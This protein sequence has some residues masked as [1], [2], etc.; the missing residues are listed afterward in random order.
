MWSMGCD[1]YRRVACHSS[2]T[3]IWSFGGGEIPGEFGRWPLCGLAEERISIPQVLFWGVLTFHKSEALCWSRLCISQYCLFRRLLEMIHSI[4][5]NSQWSGHP[6]PLGS[7][8]KRW[9]WSLIHFLVFGRVNH[10]DVHTVPFPGKPRRSFR[11]IAAVICHFSISF[12][13]A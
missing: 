9:K 1:R 8:M 3:L 4:W 7:W 6:W 10:E 12:I 13:A 5:G 11:L 2:L